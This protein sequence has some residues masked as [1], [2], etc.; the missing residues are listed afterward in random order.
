MLEVGVTSPGIFW[1]RDYKIKGS[2][3]G[4]GMRQRGLDTLSFPQ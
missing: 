1:P 4:L 3:L 2:D